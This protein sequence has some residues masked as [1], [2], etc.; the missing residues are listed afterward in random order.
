[1][2]KL[3]VLVTGLFALSTA[4]EAADNGIYLGAGVGRSQ[5]KSDDIEGIRNLDFDG[6]DLGWKV[7]AGIRPL[8]WL[9]FEANYVDFG[10]PDDTVAGVKL[11]TEGHAVSGYAVGFFALGPVDLYG[12]LG[13]VRWDSELK[14]PELG[15]LLDADGTD[16]AYGVGV[17]FRLLSLG[18]RA[19]YEI[20]DVDD[21][22][23]AN[24]VTV[25]VTY[26]FL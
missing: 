19:E 8:D 9:G 15:K 14:H 23:D 3:M 17:Q 21:L 13:A 26:T 10:E 6:S 24:M 2:R 12:K 22:D 16:L 25:G 20:F 1:M 4:A 5:V 18:V 11:R 7:I